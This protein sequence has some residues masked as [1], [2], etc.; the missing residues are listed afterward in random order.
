MRW[1]ALGPLSVISEK[2]NR[3]LG[4]EAGAGCGAP[5]ASCRRCASSRDCEEWLTQGVAL[6]GFMTGFGTGKSGAAVGAGIAAG[7][8]G[9]GGD[10]ALGV[11]AGDVAGGAAA[12]GG[13]TAAAAGPVAGCI[14]GCC[15]VSTPGGS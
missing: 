14:C 3:R 8:A 10:P 11:V 1:P 2:K 9:G 4:D 7:G 12:G 6:L 13:G 5:A 15:N